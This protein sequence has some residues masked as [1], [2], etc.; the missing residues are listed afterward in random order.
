MTWMSCGHTLSVTLCWQTTQDLVSKSSNTRLG[1]YDINLCLGNTSLWLNIYFLCSTAVTLKSNPRLLVSS[2]SWLLV[3]TLKPNLLNVIVSGDDAGRLWRY[4]RLDGSATWTPDRTRLH[5]ARR[6]RTWTYRRHL[7]WTWCVV[8]YTSA[9]SIP[10]L[11]F[12]HIFHELFH[13][14][15][16]AWLSIMRRTSHLFSAYVL[17]LI[18]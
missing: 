9:L 8:C 13:Q 15:R 16:K 17:G 4:R 6:P 5:A 18:V 11:V 10:S 3:T 14:C 2:F 12:S 1:S 7:S